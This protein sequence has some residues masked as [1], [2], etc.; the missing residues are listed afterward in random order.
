MIVIYWTCTLAHWFALPAFLLNFFLASINK[1]MLVNEWSLLFVICCLH[2]WTT[3]E[4]CVVDLC[5]YIWRM[6]WISVWAAR[7]ARASLD[8]YHSVMHPRLRLCFLMRTPRSFWGRRLAN[9][10]GANLNAKRKKDQREL[11]AHS[12]ERNEN[13]SNTRKGIPVI[14]CASIIYIKKRLP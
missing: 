3:I 4:C 14:L 10:R 12:V 9:R 8:M 1:L 13:N 6:L 7:K 5:M 11:A 2:S